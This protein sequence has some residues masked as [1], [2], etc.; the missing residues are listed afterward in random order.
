MWKASFEYGVFQMMTQQELSEA[1]AEYGMPH[2][3]EWFPDY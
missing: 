3:C 2:Y 1:I